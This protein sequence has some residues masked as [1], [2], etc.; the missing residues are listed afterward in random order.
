MKVLLIFTLLS[1]SL[2]SNSLQF[3]HI[4]SKELNLEGH[5][6]YLIG[7]MVVNNDNIIITDRKAANIKILDTNGSFMKTIGMKGY[8]PNE[9]QLPSTSVM[10]KG[11][12]YVLD[13]NLQRLNS[14]R[15]KP[16]DLIFDKYIHF[17]RN[18]TSDIKFQDKGILLVAGSF[19]IDGDYINLA[20]FDLNKEQFIKKLF[21]TKQWMEVKTKKEVEKKI[22]STYRFLS[23]NGYV[24]MTRKYYFFVHG[25]HLR[26][27]RI[28]RT[29]KNTIKFGSK[30]L[31]FIEPVLPYTELDRAL[32][33]R[34]HT[35]WLKSIQKRSIVLD[36]FLFEE[37]LLVAVFSN[38]NENTKKIDLYYN[39]YDLNGQFLEEKVL[40]HSN[41]SYYEQFAFFYSQKNNTYYIINSY[42]K[43]DG[44]IVSNLHRFKV[45]N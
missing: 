3:K 33:S 36:T 11:N 35:L 41:S 43:R 15:I 12:Y 10:R 4:D 32:R 21:Y 18:W 34:N 1:M 45:S 23:M 8:G 22:I 44:S 7:S 14:Y 28:N 31:K 2:F 25:S 30:S 9:F 5:E 42:D 37:K 24:E 26:V 17:G 19:S 29:S 40:L 38:Y 6:I 16:D 39:L 13:T 20:E 27:F